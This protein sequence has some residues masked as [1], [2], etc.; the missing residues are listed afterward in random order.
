MLNDSWNNQVTPTAIK[1]RFRHTDFVYV[2]EVTL[3]RTRMT[4]FNLN[5]RSVLLGPIDFNADELLVCVAEEKND[6]QILD[7]VLTFR[8]D[9][10]DQSDKEEAAETVSI[11]AES[12]SAI[13][14]ICRHVH[15][16]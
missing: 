1:N 4:T 5:D 13:H 14:V 2:N 15:L 10:A 3:T 6:Q 16:L 8:V 7:R 11:R 9:E 12:F